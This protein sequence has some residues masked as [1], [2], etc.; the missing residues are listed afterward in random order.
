MTEFTEGSEIR[1]IEKA[2]LVEWG[3]LFRLCNQRPPRDLA[4]DAIII[5]TG[6]W[7][8]RIHTALELWQRYARI[9][10]EAPLL[11][12]SGAVAKRGWKIGSDVGEQPYNAKWMER[13]FKKKGVPGDKIIVEPDAKNTKE[14]AD[15]SLA[16]TR[17][18]GLD[19]VMFSASPYFVPRAYSAMVASILSQERPIRTKLYSHPSED[20]PW[21][22]FVPDEPKTR[23][24]QIPV[25]IDKIRRYRQDGDVATEEQLRAYIKWLNSQHS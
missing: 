21:Q 13:W 1:G 8:D 12:P 3:K 20:L 11:V 14:M 22:G 19:T 15:F 4:V 18:N 17:E 9:Q 7:A 23:F 25:E 6:D 10:E 2:V 16:I 24:A 5:S